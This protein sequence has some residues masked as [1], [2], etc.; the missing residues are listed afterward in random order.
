MDMA[1]YGVT[2][3]Y[4][5]AV[6]LIDY[7]EILRLHSLGNSRRSIAQQVQS[8]RDT[9]ASTITV[10]NAAGISWKPKL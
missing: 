6:L 7:R 5:E 3:Y 10:T 1:R 2:I 8:S 9:V 4:R